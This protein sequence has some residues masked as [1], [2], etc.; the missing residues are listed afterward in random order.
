MERLCET[1][2]DPT[3]HDFSQISVFDPFYVISILHVLWK[4]VVHREHLRLSL[5]NKLQKY[6]SPFIWHESQGV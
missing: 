2:W 5:M 3:K 4:W 6:L 1:A